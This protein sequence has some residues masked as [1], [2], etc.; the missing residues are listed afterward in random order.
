VSAALNPCEWDPVRGLPA[1]DEEPAH[2]EATVSVG[3]DGTWH[4]C[5]ACAA[6][7]RFKGYRSRRP[8]TG[9]REGGK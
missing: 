7:P 4:L 1:T 9:N 3:A 5:D 8:I 2:A 6:L